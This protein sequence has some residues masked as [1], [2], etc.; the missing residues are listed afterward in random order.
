MIRRDGQKQSAGP[1]IARPLFCDW[2]RELLDRRAFLARCA[3]VTV[4]GLFAPALA[5]TSDATMPLSEAE[6]LALIDA[7]QLHLFP[8][9]P[10]AP[11]AREINAL[12]YLRFVLADARTD[13]DE[14]AFILNGA[15]WLE[16][17]S[18]QRTGQSFLN[19]DSDA[20]ESL[21]RETAA[22]DVGENWLSTLLLYL[23]EALLTDPAYGGNPNGIG[24]RWLE[25]VPGYPRPDA[26]TIYPRL[27]L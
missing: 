6:R 26:E 12:N 25:H 10:A 8:S 19:L 17:L 15:G 9:E 7:V 22:S 3:G 2:H 23:M 1:G 20:R 13:A 14:P 11:G 5:A 4:A 24:W 18:R 21:L 16:D 27:P